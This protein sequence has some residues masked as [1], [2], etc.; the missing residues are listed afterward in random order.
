ML[1]RILSLFFFF[2]KIL[3]SNTSPKNAASIHPEVLQQNQS[4]LFRVFFVIFFSLHKSTDPQ[5]LPLQP[6][7]TK[8]V[9]ALNM[10]I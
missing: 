4:V 9:I 10:T 2:V 8:F 5:P 7:K 6:I 3:V 1:N